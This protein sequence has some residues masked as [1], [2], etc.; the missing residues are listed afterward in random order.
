[1]PLAT[2][3]ALQNL[4][5]LVLGDHALELNQQ[6]ILGARALRC[7]HKER[8]DPMA[9][10]FFDQQDL[11]GVFA[12]QS[13]R[14]IGEHDLNLTLGSKVPNPLKARPLECRAAIAFVFE[15][16]LLR[17]FESVARRELD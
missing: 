3:R 17:D 4:R 2:A 1:M 9:S 15:D 13:I 7:L 10:K 11:I 6:L 16:P 8:L 12:A 5:P 14:R